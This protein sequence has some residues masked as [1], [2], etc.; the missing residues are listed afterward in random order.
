MNLNGQSTNVSAS[1]YLYQKDVDTN[2]ISKFSGIQL[3][4]MSINNAPLIKP[5]IDNELDR[6]A[7][8]MD[9]C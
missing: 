4:V 2:D 7:M 3:L 8:E 5:E 6:R 9:C 1:N